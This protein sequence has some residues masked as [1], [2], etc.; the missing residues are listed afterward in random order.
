MKHSD[1]LL[2]KI[3]FSEEVACGGYHTCV[4][5]GNGDLYSWGSNENG[6]LGLGYLIYYIFKNFPTQTCI[7]PISM[8][9]QCQSCILT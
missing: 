7:L 3:P 8:Y 5:T 4:V 2:L 9:I 6:C 1:R